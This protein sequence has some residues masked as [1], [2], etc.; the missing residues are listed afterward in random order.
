MPFT[1]SELMQ[2]RK[3]HTVGIFYNKG[4]GIR[5]ID[6]RFDNCCADKHINLLFK[7]LSPNFAEFALF[8]FAVTDC[9]FCLGNSLL[10]FCGT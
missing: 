2:L 6:T 8:H 1:A 9:D 4:V 3:S 10:N 5:Q 7:H